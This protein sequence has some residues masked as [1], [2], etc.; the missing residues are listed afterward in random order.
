M[1][2][3]RWGALF[4]STLLLF[5]SAASNSS[6]KKAD[7]KQ[8][9]KHNESNSQGSKESNTERKPGG[10]ESKDKGGQSRDKEHEPLSPRDHEVLDRALDEH[11]D[12]ADKE[13]AQSLCEKCKACY[14]SGDCDLQC[15]KDKCGSKTKEPNKKVSDG[16]E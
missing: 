3:F 11:A 6:D 7:N 10:E 9:D 13:K 5:G 16:K 15:V 4:F 8:I 12:K 2:G 1:T 14:N